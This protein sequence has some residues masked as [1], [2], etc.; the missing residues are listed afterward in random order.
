MEDISILFR[1]VRKRSVDH[2]MFHLPDQPDV[3]QCRPVLGPKLYGVYTDTT[4]PIR[5]LV[6]LTRDNRGKLPL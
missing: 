4:L 6:S 2:K 5:E 1:R 3:F